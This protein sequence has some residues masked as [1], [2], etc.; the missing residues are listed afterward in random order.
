MDVERLQNCRLSLVK[1]DISL[2]SYML[3][4]TKRQCVESLPIVFLATVRPSLYPLFYLSALW[5]STAWHP[6]SSD[7]IY[8]N[9]LLFAVFM[10]VCVFKQASTFQDM[11]ESAL[12]QPL[13]Q[14]LSS[15]SLSMKTGK[16]V[17]QSQGSQANTPGP[18]LEKTISWVSIHPQE[19][20]HLNSCFFHWCAVEETGLNRCRL[21]NI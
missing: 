14:K 10:C 3:Q 7:K 5:I 8:E 20:K 2:K 12:V 13:L 18:D 6:L 16:L 11:A 21:F 4:S 15:P 1:V 9:T 19:P 17:Q